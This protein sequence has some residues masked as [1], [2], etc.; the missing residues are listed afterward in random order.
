MKIKGFCREEDLSGNRTIPSGGL[1]VF[2]NIDRC[3]ISGT[4]VD[5]ELT[6]AE[7]VKTEKD[8][9]EEYFNAVSVDIDDPI[10]FEIFRALQLH[11]R[12]KGYDV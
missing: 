9:V 3:G 1:T 4:H 8:I 11:F 7:K 6:I 12:S 5:I 10:Q 2:D